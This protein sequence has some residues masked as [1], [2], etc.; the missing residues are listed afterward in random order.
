MT[1]LSKLTSHCLKVA[2]IGFTSLLIALPVTAQSTSSQSITQIAG[3]N[4]SFD[5]LVSLMDHAGIL[6]AFNGSNGKEF[7]VFAPTDDAFGRLS[8]GTIESLYKP[9]NRETLLDVLAYHVIGG[10]ITSDQLASGAV[11]SKNGLP[12]QVNVG[13]QVTINDATVRAADITA[14]NGVIHAIDT[15]LIPQR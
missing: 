8:E 11:D 2:G 12:L 10:S 9:E 13:Q 14:N 1:R 5:V 3:S 4:D 6:E 15:V 7:T